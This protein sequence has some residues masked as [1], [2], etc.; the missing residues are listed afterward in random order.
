MNKIMEYMALKKPIVQF[1]LKEGKFSAQEASLY[2][3]NSDP[4]DFAMKIISLLD[5]PGERT[6]MGEYGYSRVIRELSWDHES[7]KLIAF[8]SQIF[9]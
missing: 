7:Q 5:N 3:E 2:A 9:H 1:D 8:Y 4:K 6:R